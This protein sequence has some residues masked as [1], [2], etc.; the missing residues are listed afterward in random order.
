MHLCTRWACPDIDKLYIYRDG[1]TARE[2]ERPVG[3]PSA[4]SEDASEGAREGADVV[5]LC[6]NV[7]GSR[8]L[9]RRGKR[10]MVMAAAEGEAKRFLTP[11]KVYT[12]NPL[13]PSF[14]FML[15]PLS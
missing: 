1:D 8:Q 14:S 4:S 11:V 7:G 15:Q 2:D 5:L 6:R 10:R 3:W 13:E 12:P 9:G